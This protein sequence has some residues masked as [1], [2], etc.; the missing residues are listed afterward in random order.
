METENVTFRLGNET[1]ERFQVFLFFK[2][3]DI[4]PTWN[5]IKSTSFEASH[6]RWTWTPT[7]FFK[8]RKST[9][10]IDNP[11][12]TKYNDSAPEK[13]K[14]LSTGDYFKRKIYFHIIR[15]IQEGIYSSIIKT[16][17]KEK[18]VE[19]RTKYSFR[20]GETLW[21]SIFLPMAI[22]MVNY[23]SHSNSLTLKMV[24]EY[25]IFAGVYD[26]NEKIYFMIG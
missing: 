4:F 12:P 18:S 8:I 17:K 9:S 5:Y 13:S 7:A 19:E 26:R 23:S 3:V 15:T 20:L 10:Y 24:L 25:K 6:F 14:T 21:G 11:I 22:E 2:F 1:N 16:E